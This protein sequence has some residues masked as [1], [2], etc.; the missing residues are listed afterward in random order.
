MTC[1]IDVEG[2]GL[3][4]V[5]QV[6][7]YTVAAGSFPSLQLVDRINPRIR[8]RHFA[9]PTLLRPSARSSVWPLAMNYE[10]GFEGHDGR[11]TVAQVVLNRVHHPAFP[12]DAC[13][14]VFQRSASNI[15][16]FPRWAVRLEKVAV[17][18]SHLFYRWPGSWACAGRSPPATTD[19]S[20]L[21]VSS[22]PQRPT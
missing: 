9:V 1:E 17:I 21:S 18:A 6:T 4:V 5:R 10:A 2:F 14:K 11:L 7:D 19:P 3:D 8:S 12:H 22:K 13:S 16:Q 15:C 20:R